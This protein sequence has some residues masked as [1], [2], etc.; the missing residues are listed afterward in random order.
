MPWE[1]ELA[2]RREPHD[3]GASGVASWAAALPHQ[4]TTPPSSAAD[5]GP[6]EWTHA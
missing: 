6:L 5:G 2:V 3:P 4:S 1:G